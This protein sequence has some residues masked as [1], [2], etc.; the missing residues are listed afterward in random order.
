M[1]TTSK[2]LSQI[3]RFCK[4]ALRYAYSS[5]CTPTTDVIKIKDRLVWEKM[6]TDSTH[7]L[8]ALLPPH[9]REQGA[10]G[11]GD[12]LISCHVSELNVVNAVL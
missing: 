2:Y 11:K 12:T 3:D 7:P 1:P 5:K 10:L 8:H 9:S 6:T 4:R